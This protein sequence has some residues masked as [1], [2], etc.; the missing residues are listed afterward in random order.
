M[1]DR[2][3]LVV[4]LEPTVRRSTAAVESSPTVAA[5]VAAATEVQRRRQ[6]GPNA[7]LPPSALAAEHGFDRPVL[8]LLERRGRQMGL[9]LRRLHRSARVARTIADLA[10]TE[11][12]CAEHLDEALQHRPKELA[13]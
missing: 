1:R 7:S 5:R 10:G 2:L 4:H 12:V 3:D 6:A 9:S 11:R 13:A 8:E